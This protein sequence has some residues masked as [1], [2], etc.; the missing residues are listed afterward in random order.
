MLTVVDSVVS[1]SF[2]TGV[3]VKEAAIEAVTALYVHNS[4][5]LCSMMSC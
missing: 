4:D 1:L 5:V 3:L 2:F